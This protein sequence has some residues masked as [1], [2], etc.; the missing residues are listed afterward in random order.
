MIKVLIADDHELIRNGI[1]STLQQK[2]GF[3]IIAEAS[4]GV[5]AYD[6]IM[7]AMPDVGLLDISMPGMNGIELMEKLLKS[8]SKTKILFLTMYDDYEYIN[9]CLEVGASGY[10]VKGDTGSEIAEAIE[11]VSNGGSYFSKSVQNAVMQNYT[12]QVSKK[13]KESLKEDVNLTK[14]EKEVVK[15][16]SDGLTSIEIANQLYVS[17]RTIDTHRANLMK[18]LDVKNSVEL[19]NKVRTLDLL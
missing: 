18:K 15:L 3:E 4:N 19:I 11:T 7:D 14:R 16:V 17:P 13:K 2:G 8:G 1:R 10:L 6:K 9:R 5:E 12:N